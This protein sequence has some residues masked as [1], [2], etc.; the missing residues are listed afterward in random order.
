VRIA[1][2]SQPGN[3]HCRKWAKGLRT[4]GADV[5]VYS[6][7]EGDAGPG[8]EAVRIPP[9]FAAGG[10]YFYPC[11][12]TTGK[13]L[14]KELLA[15]RTQILHPMHVTPFGVWAMN[16]GFRPTI[17]AAVGADVFDHVPRPSTV[18]W[19]E[20]L[21]P[22]SKL[23]R[24][25]LRPYYRQRAL[26]ALGF[27]DRITA[28]NLALIQTLTRWF[29][30]AREKIELLR[31]G[32]DTDMFVH[33][34]SAEAAVAQFLAPLSR[35]IVLAPRGLKPV[36]RAD[37]ILQAVETFLCRYPHI[38]GGFVFMT[39]GYASDPVLWRH[40]KRLQSRFPQR[41][42]LVE[43]QWNEK[44]MGALW[45]R[46]AAFIS[47][48]VY[49]GYSAAVAE[50][51]YAGAVPIVDDSP[52][53]QE[54]CNGQNALVVAPFTVTEL[55]DTLARFLTDAPRYIRSIAPVNRRWIEEHSLL[56]TAAQ[57]FLALSQSLLSAP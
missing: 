40:A 9:P 16:T 1:L 3:F 17:A 38:E 53:V 24:R 13:R 35:P 29:G 4:A 14:K 49:D 7:E 22:L 47:A 10:R 32:V 46:T 12:E 8:V 41:I 56:S 34:A 18:G 2:L 19:Q 26:S 36:Y 20:N 57:R 23:K 52:A 44:R 50:G 51:R 28:D 45:K 27:A 54:W 15:R 6:F 11:Y 30:V 48:P 39:A 25:L 55:V 21:S 42:G 43:E 31:W 5:C 33:D 37:I